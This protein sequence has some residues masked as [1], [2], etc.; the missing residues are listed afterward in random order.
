M[1]VDFG[2]CFQG[3]SRRGGGKN[4]VSRG[5]LVGWVV[6]PGEEVDRSGLSLIEYLGRSGF[7]CFVWREIE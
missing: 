2:G 7:L 6:V 3:Y 4:R 1:V 5:R